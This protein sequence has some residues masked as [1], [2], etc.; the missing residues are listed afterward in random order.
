VK[1]KRVG[2]LLRIIERIDTDLVAYRP[3]LPCIAA[4]DAHLMAA[5][6]ALRNM[7]PT[8]GTPYWAVDLYRY[9]RSKDE[10]ISDLIQLQIVALR[11]SLYEYYR[12]VA[13]DSDEDEATEATDDACCLPSSTES[14]IEGED[15]T[16]IPF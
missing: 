13:D 6:A 14:V 4:L 8:P 7:H 12:A 15:S 10:R 9:D 5:T 3:E 1:A 16:E 11:K 2:A